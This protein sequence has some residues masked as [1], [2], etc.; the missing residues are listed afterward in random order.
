MHRKLSAEVKVMPVQMFGLLM[1]LEAD[2]ENES[3]GEI[4][5]RIMG[6]KNFNI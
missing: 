6:Q 4:D 1:H 5:L 3:S 2:K